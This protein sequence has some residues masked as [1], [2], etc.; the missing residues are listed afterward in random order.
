MLKGPNLQMLFGPRAASVSV[1]KPYPG[2]DKVKPVVM[3]CLTAVLGTGLTGSPERVGIKYVNLLQQGLNEHDL[4]QTNLKFELAEFTIT[5]TGTA[6]RAE[7]ARNGC[8]SIVEIVSGAKVRGPD[9]AEFVGVLLNIDTVKPTSEAELPGNLSQV[10]ETVH[11]T[12]KE[13]FF[14]LIAPATL[15]RL[16]P[17]YG[18]KH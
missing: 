4:S 2:W 1:L 13:I 18:T 16:G 3:E 12:E 14:G 7:I 6:V 5:G 15:T 8:T 9:Q 17:T 10:L 11:I